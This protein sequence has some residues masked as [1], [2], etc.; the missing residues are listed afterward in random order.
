MHISIPA[1]KAAW[2]LTALSFGAAHADT[3]SQPEKIT[4]RSAVYYGDLNLTLPQDAKIMLD[5]IE[6]AAKKACGDHATFGP[7]TGSFNRTFEECRRETV[8]RTVQQ[9]GAPVVTR[10]YSEAKRRE[11]SHRCCLLQ[12]P[13]PP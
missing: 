9:L 7:F 3:S 11:S 8:Q 1:F 6:Q 12:K 2:I 13:T 10:A 4:G 5:R